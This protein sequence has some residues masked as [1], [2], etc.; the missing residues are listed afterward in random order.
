MKLIKKWVD[1]KQKVENFIYQTDKGLKVF[2]TKNLQ[3]LETY[4]SIVVQA[5][6]YFEKDLEVPNGTLHF[7]EHMIHGNPNLFFKTKKAMDEFAFGNHNRPS[8]SDNAATSYKFMFI[9]G[10]ANTN[11]ENDIFKR[12]YSIINYPINEFEKHIELERKV[13][14]AELQRKYKPEKDPSHNFFKYL[15]NG[16][17]HNN[18]FNIIGF[19]EENIKKINSDHLRKAFTSLFTND[20]S[21]LSIQT[22]N[23]LNPKVIE[24][25]ELISSTLSKNKLGVKIHSEK[26]ENVYDEGYFFDTDIRGI[27]IYITNFKKSELAINYREDALL[28]FSQNLI[29][30]VGFKNLREKKGYVYAISANNSKGLTF[31]YFFRYIELTMS[32]ENLRKSLDELY[33]VINTRCLEFIKSKSGQKWFENELSYYLFPRT[34]SYE[35]DYA[36]TKSVLELRGYE[37]FDF[38]KAKAVAKN[39]TITD[40]EEY[41]K[42]NYIEN[43]NKFWFDTSTEIEKVKKEFHKTLFYKSLNKK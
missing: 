8:I 23:D 10:S 19:N 32:F 11:R 17:L 16:K 41:F 42:Q 37:H 21:I 25:I 34:E 1:E 14:L 27:K 38:E 18:D 12:L 4:A 30:Y 31:D 28:G 35:E 13:I 6:T 5:G 7:L 15:Y 9:Y 43:I 26:F 36:E 22:P 3:S 24:Y 29:N 40:L 2:H 33:T 20:N 39:I